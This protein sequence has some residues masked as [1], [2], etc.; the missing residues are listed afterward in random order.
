MA[1]VAIEPARVA[2]P[3][4]PP[5]SLAPVTAESASLAVTAIEPTLP[6]VA[7]SGGVA[8]TTD[9]GVLSMRREATV[10]GAEALPE[11]S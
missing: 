8:E 11:P 3:V 2:A 1:K 5:S 9:G 10:L 7:P 4:T 6:I